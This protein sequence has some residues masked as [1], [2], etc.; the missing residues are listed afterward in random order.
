MRNALDHQSDQ[1]TIIVNTKTGERHHPKWPVL[2]NL[3]DDDP[4]TI[5]K[6]FQR[7]KQLATDEGNFCGS[8]VLDKQGNVQSYR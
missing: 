7:G 4:D 1:Q 5:L 8:P 3:G 6:T 2:F